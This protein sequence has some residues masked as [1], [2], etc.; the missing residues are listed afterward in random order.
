MIDDQH[1]PDDRAPRDDG[2]PESDVPERDVNSGP[3][4][5]KETPNTAGN[6]AD[7]DDSLK[8]VLSTL[9]G[10]LESAASSILANNFSQDGISDVAILFRRMKEVAGKSEDEAWIRLLGFAETL[11]ANEY[12]HAARKLFEDARIRLSP[13]PEHLSRIEAGIKYADDY[14]NYLKIRK[15]FDEGDD[16]TA[17]G[18]LAN[19][20]QDRQDEI[21]KGLRTAIE[22]RR[23]N[24]KTALVFSVAFGVF[25]V[26][27]SAFGLITFKN[28]L[29]NPPQFS[30]PDINPM[31]NIPI[32]SS[33]DNNKFAEAAAGRKSGNEPAI[34]DTPDAGQEN[35]TPIFPD[36]ADQ[37]GNASR[38]RKPA[39]EK[40]ANETTAGT[41]TGSQSGATDGTPGGASDDAAP[42]NAAPDNAADDAP[43]D[44][45]D[46]AA[47]DDAA[48]DDATP[49]NMADG[50]PDDAAA[51]NM[52]D[53]T[54]D[55]AA[56]GNK[57]GGAR[58][59]TE[60]Q[61]G[62]DRTSQGDADKTDA[63]GNDTS[64]ADSPTETP[65]S[66][67][68][69]QRTFN[70]A[71]AYR[72]IGRARR[73]ANIRE[74]ATA[75]TKMKQFE[76]VMENACMSISVSERQL[77]TIANGIPQSVVDEVANGML[78]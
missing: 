11:W 45:P 16:E 5:G 73:M 68:E 31:S 40:T 4:A 28:T 72:A 30:L 64:A 48:P 46:S 29:S 33:T 35:S 50:T 6:D 61:V 18:L 13:P 63:K 9:E 25:L 3:L 78:E 52:A 69:I 17:E 77:N 24:R 65:L 49:D 7:P 75:G 47:P 57:A 27:A 34:P 70:C 38:T 37:T 62:A 53:G 21:R 36:D 71:L 58:A 55:D 67:A 66:D 76:R 14:I 74:N 54:P 10:D 56:A 39:A 15:H 26:G 59:N 19:I 22:T 23:T 42:G 8:D 20:S 32:L 12:H 1:L 43:D 41:T 2:R 51:G 60:T 44:T